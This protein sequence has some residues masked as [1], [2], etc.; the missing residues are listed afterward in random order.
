M[1]NAIDLHGA[2]RAEFI[3]ALNALSVAASKAGF[4]LR[5]FAETA[6]AKLWRPNFSPFKYRGR[7]PEKHGRRRGQKSCGFRGI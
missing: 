1:K 3:E 5:R 2:S 6:P 4:E 7:L